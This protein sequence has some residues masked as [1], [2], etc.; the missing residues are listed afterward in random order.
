MSQYQE[1]NHPYGSHFQPLD[2]KTSPAGPLPPVPPFGATRRPSIAASSVASF[3]SL[4]H[5]SITSSS[6]SRSG[7]YA[8]SITIISSP[9][10]PSYLDP[11][12][13]QL[14]SQRPPPP[15][16]AMPPTPRLPLPPS[17]PN[18]TS[19][20]IQSTNLQSVN[21]VEP[22]SNEFT[23]VLPPR[24]AS[25]KLVRSKSERVARLVPLAPIS[26]DI[27]KKMSSTGSAMPTATST[28]EYD[29]DMNSLDLM[30][31]LENLLTGPPRAHRRSRSNN[32]NRVTPK[33]DPRI[34]SYSQGAASAVS[35]SPTLTNASLPSSYNS[36]G[37]LLRKQTFDQMQ[38]IMRVMEFSQS[39]ESVHRSI[40]P[41]WPFYSPMGQGVPQKAREVLDLKPH[42]VPGDMQVTAEDRRII[43]TDPHR[44]L[45]NQKKKRAEQFN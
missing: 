31:M 10:P 22:E 44:H 8:P 38:S 14:Q 33:I 17:P 3:S 6:S 42:Y 24:D 21:N 5:S 28:T 9:P 36:D 2:P 34:S 32:T 43:Y 27:P 23:Q 35:T 18:S 30:D 37:S 40:E 25:R 16:I 26:P 20:N 29:E 39:Q 12:P 19:I 15:T 4:E 41:V 13:K 1:S 7:Y 11:G 45:M